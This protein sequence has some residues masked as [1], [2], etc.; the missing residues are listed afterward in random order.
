[1]TA[2]VHPE[3]VLRHEGVERAVSVVQAA[4]LDI[5][6]AFKALWRWLSTF[7]GNGVDAAAQEQRLWSAALDGESIMADVRCAMK[8]VAPNR[9]ACC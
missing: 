4:R 8:Q 1:M 6:P 9:V 2:F 7:A 5:G 3:Y